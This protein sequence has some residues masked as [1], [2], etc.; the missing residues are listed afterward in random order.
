MKYLL[1]RL[2]AFGAVLSIF[3]GCATMT[4]GG[5]TR[6][7]GTGFGAAVGALVGAGLGQ[8][9]GKN[10]AS[11]LIGAAAGSAVGAAAGYV[12]GD[13]VA[14]KKEQYVKNEDRLDDQINTVVQ[15]N[16]DLKNFNEQ[17]ATRIKDLDKEVAHLKTR[18]K[19]KKVKVAELKKK[20]EEINLLIQDAD[21][22]K[23]SMNKEMIA[24]NDYLK[25]LNQVQDRQ[26]MAKLGQE[27]D[28]LR[29]N[30]AMLDNNNKQ[31]AKL[32]K[33]LSVRK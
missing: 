28:T 15:C 29:N 1:L 30:I 24:L 10:T 8:V 16:C 26:K 7:E 33:A 19:A 13:A 18:Y 3:T 31:M 9:I 25:T 4:D 23:S 20:Q 17:T 2:I 12:A 6:A 11:T 22:R 21:Q 32:V 27:V 5:R 14:E